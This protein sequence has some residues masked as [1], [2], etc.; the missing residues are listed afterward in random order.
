MTAPA[1]ACP[2]CHTPLPADSRF[3]PKCGAA[4]PTEPGVP[5]RTLVTGEIAVSRVRSALADRYRIERV[6]GEGGMATVYLADDLKHHRK[7]AVKVMRP[8]LASSF[9]AG[10]F[11][12]EIEIAARL[13]HPH[14]LPVFD[15]G[16]TAGLLYYVMPYVKGESLRDRL[17]REG[18]LPVEETLA[19]A[20]EVADALGY[21]HREGV[22]HRDVK[23][24]NVLLSEGH[25]LVADFGIARAADEGQALTGTGLAVGTPQ[26]MSP[27]Q[28]S[29]ER[30]IDARADVYAL[31]ATMYEM[32]AGAP[33]YVGTTPRAV[34]AKALLEDITPLPVARPQVPEAAA[35]VVAKAMG[36][37][38]AARYPT[39]TELE[40][41]LAAAQDAVRSGAT[42]VRA[43]RPAGPARWLPRSPA[44][45]WGIGAAALV[46]VVAA[47]GLV[48]RGGPGAAQTGVTLAVLPFDNRGA[49]A[50][51]YVVA[52]ITDQVR[53]KLAV[54]AGFQVTGRASSE[55][56]RRSTKAP[57]AIGRELGVRYLLSA[58]V[59]W[60]KDA[61]GGGRVQ[62]VPE[63]LDVRTGTVKWQ[64]S[65]DAPLTDVFQVQADVAVQVASALDVALGA[66][67]RRDIAARPTAN[68]AAYDAFLKGKEA[69]EVGGSSDMQRAMDL[70]QQAVALDS[71]FAQAWAYL[72]RAQGLYFTQQ[73]ATPAAGDRARVSAERA[74]ALAPDAADSYGAMASYYLFVGGDLVRARRELD[75][76]LRR[77]PNDVELILTSVQVERAQARYDAALE[78]LTRARSLDPRNVTVLRILAGSLLWLRR[79]SEALAATDAGL[80][81]AP[82]MPALVEMKAMVM[83]TR[84]DLPGARA[85]LREA[86]SRADPTGLVTYTALYW[87]LFW[88]LED[89]QQAFLLRLSPAQFGDDRAAWALAVAG[90]YAIRGDAV[91]SRA[92]GDTAAA[93]WAEPLRAAPNDGPILA[94]SSLSLAYAGRRAEALST[95][96]RALRSVTMLADQFMRHYYWHVLA[97]AYTYAGAPDKAIDLLERL[98]GVPYFISRAWLRIDPSWNALRSSPRF[99]RLVA[100]P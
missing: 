8:E 81:I 15:S 4:T 58:A 89:A 72:A 29:G 64:Q 34:L 98:L 73:A 76:G 40:H 71:T 52:G 17:Q 33:P 43:R 56:Y 79:P 95:A 14:I 23:P 25:A 20:R 84:G 9:G 49:P 42:A 54:L 10:R 63:L 36:R 91:R 48:L 5:P 13:S 74:Q 53:G 24:A 75:A 51:D 88:A 18:R 78:L 37:D 67:E 70:F 57:A 59:S 97:R 65:F 12:R 87:D 62:V 50:D 86:L 92:Y 1:S 77:A 69:L 7:V 30:D 93:A 44:A 19:L 41:A 26:Y 66:G 85:W 80:S 31:G 28:A 47:L 22:I 96:D 39:C 90:T 16:E 94:Y 3:C 61:R 99:Q 60:A 32:L 27:E 45:R 11:L 6:L 35:A 68:L 38:P 83:L 2:A 100:G 46:L 21:A 55:Q 82:D